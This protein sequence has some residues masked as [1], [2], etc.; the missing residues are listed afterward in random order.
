MHF[1]SFCYIGVHVNFHLPITKCQSIANC[2]FVLQ[3]CILYNIVVSAAWCFTRQHTHLIRQVHVRNITDS[4]THGVSYKNAFKKHL[5]AKLVPTGPTINNSL[6]IRT[7]NLLWIFVLLLIDCY[8]F[9][10]SI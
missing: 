1:L 6:H 5:L 2:I 7:F 8:V 3:T 10:A 9:Y 4:S